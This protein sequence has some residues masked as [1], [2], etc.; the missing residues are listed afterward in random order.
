MILLG[1]KTKDNPKGI[2]TLSDLTKELQ[3][4]Q[5][6]QKIE[7]QKQL[8]ENLTFDKFRAEVSDMIF[9]LLLNHGAALNVTNVEDIEKNKMIKPGTI[10]FNTKTGRFR[11]KLKS[12]WITLN[13]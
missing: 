7:E 13:T 1:K 8:I 5:F 11:G 6:H 12:K 2:Y 3:L 10:Y 4:K 9:E